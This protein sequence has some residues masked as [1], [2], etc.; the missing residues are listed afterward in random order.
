[1][2]SYAGGQLRWT[3]GTRT[4]RTPI[5]VRPVALAAP[6]QVSGSYNVTFGFSGA[7]SATA[8]GLIPAAITA[9]T[10]TQDPDQTFDPADP[11]GTVAV[12]VEI[13]AGT[14]YA[15]FSLFDGD[16]AAGSDIDLYVYRGTTFAGGSGNGGSDEEVNLLNPVAGTYTVYMHGWGLPTGTSPFKLHTW[17]LGS[18]DAGNMTVTAPASGVIVPLP[19]SASTQ[20][21]GSRVKYLGSVAYGGAAAAVNRRS[22]ASTR[23]DPLAG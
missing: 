9:G 3:D 7:F 21:A 19:R 14:T 16:V 20:W 4:V 23:K 12:T 8:R 11:S 17:A 13:P 22:C 6:A 1:L 10:V 5:V 15:R 18:A 2:N